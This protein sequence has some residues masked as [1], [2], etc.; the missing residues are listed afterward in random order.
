M[1][2]DEYTEQE[3]D[4]AEDIIAWLASQPWCTGNVGMTGISW[5][6]F[7]SLQ[8]AARQPPALKAII[9]LCCSDDRYADGV[10]YFGGC[11]LTEDA[12]WASFILALG[13][14]PPDPQIVGD[15]WRAMWQERLESTTCWS[16]QWLA[17]QRRDSYWQRG[18][19]SE[20]FSRIKVPVYAVSGWDDT[21]SNSVS[22]CL[23]GLTVPAK[24]LVG[25]WTHSFPFMDSP[26]PA[27]GFLQE[28]VRWWRH[29]LDGEETGIMDEPAM[30]RW[31]TDP[32]RPAPFYPDHPGRFVGDEW[33]PKT[34]T[35]QAFFLNAA[36]LGTVAD[37]A[38]R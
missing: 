34:V 24:G 8:V 1:L 9:A 38:A 35:E 25:P 13:A 18:S 37:A 16:S 29:W 10:H 30:V 32:H 28:A 17:H 11:L 14:M 20:D 3:Q 31:I 19:V 22:R 36:G 7:N 2:P 4:D 12:M 26:G 23:T 21:Y 6:R 5:G 33:P 27:I 15:R